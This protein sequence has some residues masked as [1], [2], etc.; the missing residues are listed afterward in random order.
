MGIINRPT[1]Q[2]V[3]TRRVV[4]KPVSPST[5]LNIQQSTGQVS[6]YKT[7]W[8]VAGFPKVGKSTLGS[9]FDRC[10][11]LCTS[12]KEV[13]S[14][15]VPYIVIESWGQ[16]ME[17]TDELINHKEKYGYKFLVIDFIDAVWTLCISAVCE[18]LDVEYINDAKFGK[19]SHT[20]DSFFRVWA[21]ELVASGYGLIF[22]THVV[23]R[24]VVDPSGSITKTVCS[25]PERARNILFPLVNVIGSMGYK[26][27]H[28]NVNGKPVIAKKRVISFEGNEYV[29]AGD[30]DGVLPKEVI[31]L[32]DPKANFEMFKDYYEGRRVKK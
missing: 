11:Y 30:R 8:V 14:L 25:L 7:S 18:K 1:G 24:D 16:L 27:V 2:V 17:I 12:E 6:I 31:L 10:L 26:T 9:G 13:G 32:N 21:L 23:Q 20:A 22:I 4:N 19:G 29:E 28:V 3:A 15:Q 5:T